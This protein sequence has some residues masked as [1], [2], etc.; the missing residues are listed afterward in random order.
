[1]KPGTPTDPSF[2]GTGP[3]QEGSDN[4]SMFPLP[5]Q[6]K[7][8]FTDYN[9]I[10]PKLRQL[11]DMG[12]TLE[13]EAKVRRKLRYLDLS[14]RAERAVNNIDQD[15]YYIPVKVID[16]NIRRE[17]A[18]YIQYLTGSKRVAVFQNMSNP[19]QDCSELEKDF[20]SRVRYDDWLKPMFRTIDGFQ[21]HGYSIIEVLFDQ[22]RIG[23]FDIQDVPYEDFPLVLDARNIQDQELLVRYCYYTRD[24]LVNLYIKKGFDPDGISKVIDSMTSNSSSDTT[25]RLEKVFFK[26]DGVVHVGW[27]AL[28][29]CSTWLREPQ[30]L[31]LGR[32]STENGS[33][34]PQAETS[35]PFIYFQYLISENQYIRDAKGRIVLDEYSQQ[36]A[37]CL[38]SSFVTAHDRAAQPYFSSSSREEGNAVKQ[39]QIKLKPG[40]LIQGEVKQF[41]L[42]PPDPG[43]LNA[44][45]AIV[46]QNAQENS[47]VNYAV[48]NRKDS[49]KTAQEVRAAES[50][51]QMLSY[52]QISLFSTALR[53][54]YTLIW[55]LYSSRVLAQR[56]PPNPTVIKTDPN[57]YS[58]IYSI[59]PAGDTDVIERQEKIASMMQAWPVIQST[60]IAQLFLKNIILYMFPDEAP[61][62][63]QQ[64]QDDQTKTNLILQLATVV[65][66][67]VLDPH[68]GQLNPEAKPYAAQLQNLEA[69]V[70]QVTGT[71]VPH[72]A[73]HPLNPHAIPN[74]TSNPAQTPAA[75]PIPGAGTTPSEGSR[76]LQ[77]PH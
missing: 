62:Y 18:K 77:A 20:T 60:P 22:D 67:L 68:T 54:L 75:A 37:S 35:Y 43:L 28:D 53:E 58:N 12:K 7:E 27:S 23:H 5:I 34:Q 11:V 72:Q 46:G 57:A 8:D 45:M 64:F 24:A 15:A 16:P 3:K 10:Q 42:T 41:Q 74:P 9:I 36:A 51:S 21:S 61:E 65:K 55:G 63:L 26:K 33:P 4:A 2:G 31:F 70:Q 50:D 56:I 52:I 14:D 1:M 29:K 48:N 30:P 40:V 32:Y 25:A 13:I 49:R 17:Q 76:L 44:I 6:K 47:Q 71:Q 66:G 19:I 59:K 38:M 69:Q 73:Q 39:T